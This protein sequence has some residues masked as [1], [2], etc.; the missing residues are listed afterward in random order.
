M[1][2]IFEVNKII[3]AIL[4]NFK[5]SESSFI[6]SGSQGRAYNYESDK[7]FKITEDASEYYKSL[8]F[9]GRE[10][11]H[12][13]NIFDAFLIKLNVT[14]DGAKGRLVQR[15]A[16][17]IISE[18]IDTSQTSKLKRFEEQSLEFNHLCNMYIADTYGQAKEMNKLQKIAEDRLELVD[19][20][21][22][23]FFQMYIDV[24]KVCIEEKFNFG[25]LHSGNLGFKNGVLTFFDLGYSGTED[26]K[27]KKNIIEIYID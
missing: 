9:I 2:T 14:V 4:D 26:N 23:E 24:T 7:V 17:V 8:T 25:D 19:V 3:K 5:V 21:Y 10:V 12:I 18:K 20:E 16:Y 27:G 22:H 1:Y 11:K 13:A 6:D 15:D